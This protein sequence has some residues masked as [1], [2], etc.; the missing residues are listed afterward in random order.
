MEVPN[1]CISCGGDPDSLEWNSLGI[2]RCKKC[3]LAWKKRFDLPAD[4]YRDLN[5]ERQNVGVEKSEARY[6]NSRD[7]FKAIRKYL[8]QSGICDVGCGEGS[9]LE[10][11]REGGY[12]NVWGIEPSLFYFHIAR[13]RGLDVVNGLIR[14]ISTERAH[15]ELAAATLFHVIEH[16]SDPVESINVLRNELKAGGILVIETPDIDAPMQRATGHKN[17]LIYHEHLFYWNKR[18]LTNILEKNGFRVLKVV[19]RSFDWKRS[20]IRVSLMRLGILS[21]PQQQTTHSTPVHEEGAV[22]Q[23]KPGTNGSLIREIVRKSLAYLAHFLER[24]DYLL[25]VAKRI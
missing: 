24:D 1:K 20:S 21:S 15:R 25:V 7:R 23:S 2:L 11:L 6:R 10:A 19:R 9:F 8:P 5:A 3:G 13:E 14:D 12:K 16:L 17:P 18:S 4:Y 22:V